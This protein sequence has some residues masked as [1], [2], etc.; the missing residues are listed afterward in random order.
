MPT[1]KNHNCRMF[2]SRRA[3]FFFN[4]MQMIIGN[5]FWAHFVPKQTKTKFPIFAQKHGFN[6]LKKMSIW[7]LCK[8]HNFVVYMQD[9]LFS[10]QTIIKHYF[11]AHCCLKTQRKCPIFDQNR[12]LS[13]LIK[14]NVATLLINILQCRKPCFLT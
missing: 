5:C 8:L 9:G 11:K 6:Q 2:E 14:S 4:C 10:L 3:W 1:M 12:G 13:A 7:R